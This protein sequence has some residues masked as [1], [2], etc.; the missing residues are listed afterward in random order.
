MPYAPAE[1][2]GGGR[3]RPALP[4]GRRPGDGGAAAPPQLAR[5]IEELSAVNGFL[6][7][8]G[9]AWSIS[10]GDG[11]GEQHFGPEVRQY[12]DAA[13]SDFHD[14]PAVPRPCTT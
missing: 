5:H 2:V 9:L 1:G 3:G 14:V 6:D 4:G 11:I 10:S 7:S 12:L 8:R 13:R